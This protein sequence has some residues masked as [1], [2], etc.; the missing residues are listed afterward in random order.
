MKPLLVSIVGARPQ[1]I[2]AAPLIQLIED[3]GVFQHLLLHTGQ[4][5]DK[6][7]SDV[8]FRELNITKPKKNL[9]VAPG[10]HA[11]QT[12]TMMQGIEEFLI[13]NHPRLL[14]VYG[15]TNSTL[16][17]AIVGV[18]LGI[19]IA[20][21]EAGLRSFNKRMPEEINRIVADQFS[22]LLFAPTDT[23]F[24]NLKKE[25]FSNDSVHVVGDLMVDTV[26][27]QSKRAKKE[28][29][30][31]SALELKE[32]NFIL[33]TFHRQENTDDP[34]RLNKIWST[35]LEIS[36]METVVLPLHPRTRLRLKTAGLSLDTQ[37]NLTV[38]EPQGYLDT[39][40][41]LANSNLLLTDS[42]GMQKEAY[43]L[44][45]PC[46]TMRDESEWVELL[47]A[48]VNRLADPESPN[49]ILKAV[50][51][52]KTIDVQ[53]SKLALYGEGNTATRIH[54]SLVDFLENK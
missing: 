22:D 35:I 54:E 48:G 9:E 33:A 5:F 44:G 30:I 4:H 13:E 1:F 29:R 53:P 51:H 3:N 40:Q 45:I 8:F 12:G 17:G 18:R 19:P 6:N 26:V 42:G 2:K 39:L 28:S 37:A 47:E 16:A 11:L 20:H 7:M 41:L 25:G 21:I 43:A 15:D 32:G 31:L 38:V 23:A 49:A 27:H 50:E 14:L 46:V 24:E 36:Q 34:E 52:M 10:S